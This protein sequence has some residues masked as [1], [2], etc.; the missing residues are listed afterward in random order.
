MDVVIALGAL[1]KGESMHFEM[2]STATA[3]GLMEVGCDTG[4]PVVDGILNC[5]TEQ[6]VLDRCNVSSEVVKSLPETA[7]HMAS[8]RRT[9][10]WHT[11]AASSH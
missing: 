11:I 7:L 4:V 1:I 8:L 10:K 9:R 3:K 6:Q 2:I 5:M